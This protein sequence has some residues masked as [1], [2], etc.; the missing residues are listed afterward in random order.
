MVV[1]PTNELWY[2]APSGQTSTATRNGTGTLTSA[3]SGRPAPPAHAYGLYTSQPDLAQAF[4]EDVALRFVRVE[5][6][7]GDCPQAVAHAVSSLLAQIADTR[8]VPR[9]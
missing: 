2:L 6:K 5:A 1:Y 8:N 4:R 7:A 9:F 3:H